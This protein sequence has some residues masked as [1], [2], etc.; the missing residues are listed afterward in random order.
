MITGSVSYLSPIEHNYNTEFKL[1]PKVRK[2]PEF[3]SKPIENFTQNTWLSEFTNFSNYKLKRIKTTNNTI[4]MVEGTSFEIPVYVRDPSNVPNPYSDTNITYV[5]KKDG[6]ALYEFNATNNLKGTHTI[7]IS[8]ESCTRDISGTYELEATNRYGTTVSEP[9]V[10]DVINKNYHPFLYKNLVV[11]GCGEL[12]A[13]GWTLDADIIVKNFSLYNRNQYSIPYEL[14]KAGGASTPTE[15]FEFS[16]YQNETSL[17]K[18]FNWT[19][20]P[21]TFTGSLG[22]YKKWI[23]RRY[24]PCLVATDGLTLTNTGPQDSFFPS[25]NYVDTYNKNSN[26]FKLNDIIATNKT[27]ISRDK[28]RFLSLGGKAKTLAYQDVDISDISGMVD[29]EVYGIDRLVAHFFA[30]VGIGISNYE[31]EYIDEYTGQ[32]VKDNTIPTTLFDYKMGIFNEKPTL[33]PEYNDVNN[34]PRL[35]TDYD[36]VRRDEY[37]AKIKKSTKVKIKPVA[38][39]KTTIRLDFIN[40]ND[41]IISSENI[42]GPTEKDIW[43][44]KEKFFIPYYLGNLYGWHTNATNQV[45]E[46]YSQSYTTVDAIRGVDSQF[47]DINTDWIKRYHYPL[48]PAEDLAKP[49]SDLIEITTLSQYQEPDIFDNIIQEYGFK[50]SFVQEHGR[51]KLPYSYTD[52]A[53][54]SKFDRGASAFFAVQRDV[55]VPRGT[56]TIRVNIL[57]SHESEVLYDNNPRLKNWNNQTLYYDFFTR[58]QSSE[59][60]VEYGN[61]RCGV[62]A[63]HLSLHPNNVEVSENYNTYKLE[64]SGSVWSKELERLN[65]YNEYNSLASTTTDPSNLT[66]KYSRSTIP[67]PTTD[68]TF[69]KP[70]SV[71]DIPA[72]GLY[73][74]PSGSGR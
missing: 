41:N 12:G 11:N 56:R 23:I 40:A 18:W 27:Y 9:I 73:V 30:Y 15:E 63:T 7:T 28:I 3:I 31:I 59:K 53:V 17:S 60:L 69:D 46:F 54:D 8:S 68:N 22:D 4:G 42:Q 43:A 44:V 55:V 67:I 32:P 47:K 71:N 39:D 64:L 72:I 24:H 13:D 50:K 25:W 48:L 10:I 35:V 16:F 49:E 21:N 19:K 61:P 36:E 74:Q 45:F 29:G 34:I 65:N 26:L 66:Y 51:T 6:A 1:Y 37:S 52:G 5:W 2:P 57:F 70:L 58:G 62:T 33:I 20:D 38:Y 14:Y